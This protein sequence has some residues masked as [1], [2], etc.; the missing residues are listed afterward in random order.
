LGWKPTT[1]RNKVTTL[2]PWNASESAFC[3]T[4][5]NYEYAFS[6]DQ[7]YRKEKSNLT[8]QH[9]IDYTMLTFQGSE[10]NQNHFIDEAI[11]FSEYQFL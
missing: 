2:K 5:F 7:T 9:T 8:T 10:T 4:S 11:F 6:D 1:Q 3:E